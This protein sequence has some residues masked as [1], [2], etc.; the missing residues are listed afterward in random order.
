MLL[1]KPFIFAILLRKFGREEPK[2]AKEIGF[3]IG[4]LSEF[5]I[6]LGAL[7]LN[8]SVISE[9]AAY[10]IQAATIITFLASSYIIVFN[11]PTPI[12]ISDRLRRD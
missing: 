5:S 12:A 10:L 4:Q 1:F 7:A 3:R 8:V 2:I 6:L 9:K 11:F